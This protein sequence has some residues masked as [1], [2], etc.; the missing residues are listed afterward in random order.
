MNQAYTT[1]PV[2]Q[3]WVT[4]IKC[5]SA[6][7]QKIPPYIIFKGESLMMHWVSTSSPAGWMFAVNNKG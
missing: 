2:C 7:G 6:T 5:I 3:E 1:Q 4:V